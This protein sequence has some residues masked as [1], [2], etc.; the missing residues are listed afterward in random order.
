MVRCLHFCD[1]G[2]LGLDEGAHWIFTSRR[3]V[4]VHLSTPTTLLTLEMMEMMCSSQES[5]VS[6]ST[7]VNVLMQSCTKGELVDY[8]CFLPRQSDYLAFRGIVW[9]MVLFAAVNQVFE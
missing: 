2:E 5:V 7:R 9:L 8:Q 6:L 4:Q 1:V 3:L